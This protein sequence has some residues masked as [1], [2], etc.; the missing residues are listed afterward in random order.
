MFPL[1]FQKLQRIAKV[2]IVK[3]QIHGQ[4]QRNESQEGRIPADLAPAEILLLQ[5]FHGERQHDG[6]A[7]KATARRQHSQ[8]RARKPA[9]LPGVIERA[10]GEEK[11]KALGIGDVQKI[12]GRENRKIEDGRFRRV[13]DIFFLS[14]K[15]EITERSRTTDVRNDESRGMPVSNEEM[16]QVD[17][18]RIKRKEHDHEPLLARAF[19]PVPELRDLE[20]VDHIPSI[21]EFQPPR[22]R[23]FVLKHEIGT[24]AEG[25]GYDRRKQRERQGISQTP[26]G[27]QPA[28]QLFPVHLDRF[29]EYFVWPW[30][31]HLAHSHLISF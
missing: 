22:G 31:L 8:E 28:S 27:L 29:F 10:D 7:G 12:S 13:P 19:A 30:N 24:T 14:E 26:D 9:S 16:N 2:V 20:V 21:P 4:T 25:Q 1:V 17:A 3:E 18:E 5:V 6:E 23:P 15:K 11:E